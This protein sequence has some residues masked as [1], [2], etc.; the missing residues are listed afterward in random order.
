[1]SKL[2]RPERLCFGDTIGIIAPASA[3]PDHK[4]VDRAAEALER[5]GFKPK[6]AKNIR[7]R[8]GFLAGTDRERATD[9]MAMFTNKNVKAI[10]C[11]RGG[12]G[13]ARIL[14]RLDYDVIRRHPKILSGY[15]DITSLHCALARKVNLISIHAP[16]L[17]GALADPKVPEFTKQSFLR[18]VMEAKPAGSICEGYD[19]KTVSIL[20]GGVAEGRLIGG[21]LSVLCASLGTPFAP[22]FKGKILFFEDIN[23]KPYK[24]DRMLTQLL[25]AG[26][27]SQIAGVAVGVNADCNDPDA[28]PGGEYRQ[29]HADV[30]K[31][32]LAS[33]RVPVVTGL[34][35]GHVALNATI[36]VGASARLDAERGDLI[37]TESAVS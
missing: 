9:L 15:S 23:E 22:S 26:I 10:I 16:M 18:T 14:D 4:A 19:G 32:R 24:L 27:F 11:L 34:P 20:R 29:S 6:L 33:L 35:F 25:N 12:Y 30:V 17:N 5:F 37:I 2:I 36:P 8:L 13:A 3:P 21:N 7:A 1:M 31:E 28:K